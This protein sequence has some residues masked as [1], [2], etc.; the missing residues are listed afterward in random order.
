M[1]DIIIPEKE[2]KVKRLFVPVT[3]TEHKKIMTYCR[4]KRITLTDLIRFSLKET[5]DF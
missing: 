5:I 1:K 4:Q 3:P 2:L